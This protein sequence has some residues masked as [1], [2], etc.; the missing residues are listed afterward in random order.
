VNVPKEPEALKAQITIM[1]REMKKEVG[2]GIDWWQWAVW[3]GNR[4]PSYLWGEW[5]EELK[6][7]GYNWQ[8]FLKLMSYHKHDMILW[9]KGEISWKDFVEKVVESL[10]GT[11][12]EMIRR[13]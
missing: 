9:V 7:K 4:L 3:Y 12:G 6:A 11:I 8:K 10:K 1:R 2:M 13:G 5:E